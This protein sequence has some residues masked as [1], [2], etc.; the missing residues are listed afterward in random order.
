[1]TLKLR[2][3]TT[4]KSV[5]FPVLVEQQSCDGTVTS[6]RTVMR[7]VVYVAFQTAA[8][9]PFKTARTGKQVIRVPSPE[10]KSAYA[11]FVGLFFNPHLEKGGGTTEISWDLTF[12]ATNTAGAS[13]GGSGALQVGPAK[14]TR[15]ASPGAG[16]VTVSVKF[17]RGGRL[18][19]TPP[20]FGLAYPPVCRVSVVGDSG[21]PPAVSAGV[22][23][24]KVSQFTSSAAF[25]RISYGAKTQRGKL[26]RGTMILTDKTKVYKRPFS[27]RL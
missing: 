7:S 23:P 12:V 22:I 19:R 15:Q 16:T 17:S 10:A 3:P 14:V 4:K 11:G 1:M 18:L 20:Y 24:D 21:S 27:T 2:N 6:S 13:T 25:C 5:T 26:L 9:T 8:K